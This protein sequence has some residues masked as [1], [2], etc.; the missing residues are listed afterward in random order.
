MN[1]FPNSSGRKDASFHV[2]RDTSLPIISR[3]AHVVQFSPAFKED[4][5][6]MCISTI[7]HVKKDFCRR[8]MFR[9]FEK[10]FGYPPPIYQHKKAV[11]TAP[12]MREKLKEDCE[13]VTPITKQEA[14]KKISPQ[15]E[16]KE[17]LRN[18]KAEVSDWIKKRKEFNKSFEKACDTGHFL[19]YKT[20]VTPRERRF[21]QKYRDEEYL[22]ASDIDIDA[23]LVSYERLWL[24]QAIYNVHVNREIVHFYII[25]W[26]YSTQ[27]LQESHIYPE[28]RAYL[29]ISLTY[30]VDLK[31]TIG[32]N[33]IYKQ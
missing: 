27:G 25:D 22:S 19:K 7:P 26:F 31:N 16:E 1:G 15:I 13:D 2:H 29:A 8:K 6:E 3:H 30:L 21:V 4:M 5:G 11:Y 17:D 10:V 24:K 32:I 23:P 9:T 28:N 18:K 14:R 33:E 12:R 20:D